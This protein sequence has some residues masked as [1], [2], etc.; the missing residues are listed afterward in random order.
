MFFNEVFFIGTDKRL[1]KSTINDS[2]NWTTSKI[3]YIIYSMIGQKLL[4]GYLDHPIKEISIDQLPVGTYL[5]RVYNGKNFAN[6]S[7]IKQ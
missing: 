7:F 6:I 2:G 5:L 1:Y 3:N 4:S